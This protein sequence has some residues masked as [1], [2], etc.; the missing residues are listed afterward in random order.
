MENQPDSHK[1][2]TSQQE[3]AHAQTTVVGTTGARQGVTGHGVRY[4]LAF[5][6]AGVV[7]AFILIG[8]VYAS[9]FS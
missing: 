1:K 6:L 7:V 8:V 5:G 4:V 2:F 9:Y 3:S